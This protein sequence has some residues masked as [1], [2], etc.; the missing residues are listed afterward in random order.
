MK[1]PV[2]SSLLASLILSS[3]TVIS[4]DMTALANL[5]THLEQARALLQKPNVENE[6]A[7]RSAVAEQLN[8]ALSDFEVRKKTYG[9]DLPL[10][11]KAVKSAQGE[12]ARGKTAKTRAK[13]LEFVKQALK[14]YEKGRSFPTNPGRSLHF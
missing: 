1:P 9:N 2:L 14:Q 12:M 8:L 7:R 5:Q 3:G 10:V 13:A 11:E 4:M 6:A